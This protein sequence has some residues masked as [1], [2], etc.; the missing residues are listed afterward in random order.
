MSLTPRSAR[1]C[2]LLSM[3]N[4]PPVVG[5]LMAT[6]FLPVTIVWLFVEALRG[7]A[8]RKRAAVSD[9]R[10]IPGSRLTYR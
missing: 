4:Y 10:E 2:Y 3:R 7:R 5:L 8:E 1:Q 6:V 9:R